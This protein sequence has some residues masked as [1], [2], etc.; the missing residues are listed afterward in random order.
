MPIESIASELGH[1][2]FGK[3]LEAFEIARPLRSHFVAGP[4]LLRWPILEVAAPERSVP[5]VEAPDQFSAGK[6]APR[7]PWCG[8]SNFIP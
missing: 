7:L 5:L 2:D 1:L 6:R 8:P 4:V 3:G